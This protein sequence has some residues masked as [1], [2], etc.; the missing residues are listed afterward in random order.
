MPNRVTEDFMG[1]PAQPIEG[2]N[3]LK[4]VLAFKASVA[5]G[6]T[7]CGDII[8]GRVRVDTCENRPCNACSIGVESTVSAPEKHP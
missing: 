4:P 3:P 5:A 6:L 2:L 7:I 1:R 8:I